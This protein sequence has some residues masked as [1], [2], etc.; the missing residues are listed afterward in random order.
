MLR[1][2]VISG[3]LALQVPSFRKWLELCPNTDLTIAVWAAMGHH[4]KIGLDR[5]NQPAGII[6]EIPS[7]RGAELTIYTHHHDFQVVLD[8]GRKFLGL[9]DNLPE[10]P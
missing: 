3:I 9:P 4:L 1:H 7:N 10:P 6:A 8:M 5:K 2:E